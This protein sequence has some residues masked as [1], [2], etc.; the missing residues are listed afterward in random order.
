MRR[1]N[2]TGL[3][4]PKKHYMVDISGKIDQI[5]KLIDDEHYFTINRA[6]QY[7]KTT[8][9]NQLKNTILKNSEYICVSISFESVDP[10]DFD[11]P[12][13]FC[14]MY[15]QKISDALDFSTTDEEY[16]ARWNNPDVTDIGMLS[17]HITK[18]CKNKKLVLLID[19]VDKSTDNGLFLHFLGML[20]AK[21]LARQA[22]DDFT[23]HSVILAGVTDIKNLKLKMINDGLHE[24]L[25]GEGRIFNSPWNIAAHFNVD[26]SFSSEEISTMLY[27]YEK[28]NNT[29]MNIKSISEAIYK[30]TSGYPFLVSRICQCI[31]EELDR[32]WSIDGVKQ[33][34][35]YIK[36]TEINTLFEDM[37]KNLKNSKEIYDFM[38]GLL[39]LGENEMRSRFDDTVRLC[40]MFGYIQTNPMSGKISVANK[41]F[42]AVLIEYFLT[43]EGDVSY[44]SKEASKIFRID[45]TRGGQFD[46]EL[47]LSK[48]A[49]FYRQT[50]SPKNI[51]V[52]EKQARLIFL[53]FLHALINGEGFYH[54]ES[55]FTDSR[56]MDIVVDFGKNQYIL[57]LKLWRGEIARDR[58]Y[59]QLLGYLES[60]NANEGYLLTFDFREEKNKQ[61]K[62]EWVEFG[63]V[64]I[65]DVVV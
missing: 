39:I 47:C 51:P 52:M 21:Y 27:D 24:P 9:L 17:R 11:T 45:V 59:D 28:D 35:K 33:A 48:F 41:I 1:F 38:Y 65:F 10:H 7:G 18:I 64:K 15:L 61:R 60:K 54:I 4:V 20:R 8:T 50:F 49:E 42:E 3:C 46:M 62:A 63:D 44:K 5:L 6:R 29:G 25:A 30:Y 22:G 57:E 53:A 16:S 56:R 55:A 34:V 23:F 37:F 58:A 14:K 26:M 43:V 12:S 19:E 13:A 31:D 40:E 32:D 2:V 36:T